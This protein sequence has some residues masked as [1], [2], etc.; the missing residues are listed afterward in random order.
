[1]SESGARRMVRTFASLL[2]AEVITRG[3]AFAASIVVVRVLE[4]ARF[5]EFAFALA[6]AGVIGV[7]VE[8]GLSSLLIRDVSARPASASAVLGAALKAEA[9]LGVVVFGGGGA[10]AAAG[11]IGGPAS[12]GALALAFA[13]T[14]ALTVGRTFEAALTGGGHAQF[15]T[16]AR[17]V[18]GVALVGATAAVAE[19][20]PGVEAFL[21]GWLVAEAL[22]AL[23]AGAACGARA[24]RPRLRGPVTEVTA[25]LRRAVPFALLAGFSLLYGRIDIIMLGALAG[26]DD[27]GNYAV[28]SRIGETALIVPIY[29]GAAFLA[30]I[31]AGVASGGADRERTGAA[32][33]FILVACVPAAFA[34]AVTADPLV[35]LVAGDEYTS[36]GTLLAILSPVLVLV[37]SYAVLSNLQIALDQTATLVRITATGAVVKVALNFAAIPLWGVEGAAATAVATEAGVVIAQWYAARAHVETG[38]LLR[39]CGR[40][41]LCAGAMVGLGVVALSLGSWVAGLVVGLAVFAALAYGLRL[42]SGAEV[43]TAWASLRGLG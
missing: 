38:A 11:V 20:D 32:L 29:F 8:L 15:V 9:V 43:S 40:L 35:R 31:S 25:L 36:A 22:G 6:V 28:A 21:A 14:A 19:L 27:V 13:F 24:L 3:T 30:T 33:R 2:S 10:L 12:G 18:R 7:A 23:V 41:A 39:W 4:P 5:G 17:T 16:L 42:L 26:D 34:L 1:M 37:A